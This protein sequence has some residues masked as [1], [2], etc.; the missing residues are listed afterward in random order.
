MTLNSLAFF[1]KAPYQEG[2]QCRY[3]NEDSYRQCPYYTTDLRRRC[4]W[5]AGY[6]D[7]DMAFTKAK[8][9]GNEPK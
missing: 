6:W 9:E 4:A 5:L 2:V 8:G 7:T 1:D 3:D